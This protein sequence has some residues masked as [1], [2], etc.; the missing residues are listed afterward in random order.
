M[1]MTTPIANP[2]ASKAGQMKATENKIDTAKAKV[3]AQAEEVK[4]EI[5]KITNDLT[6][7]LKTKVLARVTED[8]KKIL[9]NST[10]SIND[11]AKVLLLTHGAVKSR[12]SRGQ[13]I[14]EVVLGVINSTP[15]APKKV[16]VEQLGTIL[17]SLTKEE[18]EKIVADL[19][20]ASK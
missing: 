8:A 4:Y 10:L 5:I 16:S 2:I 7:E 19:K 1:N 17:A 20:K 14:S 12:V 18:R 9:S 13:K 11:L 3:E 6:D 15:K